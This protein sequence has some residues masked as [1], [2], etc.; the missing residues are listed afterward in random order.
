HVLGTPPAFVLS[1]DQT[2]HKMKFALSLTA[3][4]TR[5]KFDLLIL[6][7]TRSLTSSQTSLV[8]QF[9]KNNYSLK[10]HL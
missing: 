8:V 6:L 5:V 7:L 4:R 2:L 1:Q 3:L 9:S 10:R